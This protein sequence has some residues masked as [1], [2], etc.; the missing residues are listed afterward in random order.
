MK[1]RGFFFVLVSLML[2]A[3]STSWAQGR[4]GKD[5]ANC[6]NYLNFYRDYLKQANY[7]EASLQWS[8]AFRTCP[9]SASQLMLVDGQK[10]M[11]R[12]LQNFKGTE[13]QRQKILDTL[14]ML[15]DVRAANYPKSC[16][17][18][19]QSQIYDKIDF[20]RGQDSSIV[21]SIVDF[22]KTYGC[23]VDGQML[24]AAMKLTTKMYETKA[25]NDE[26]VLGIYSKLSDVFAEK[27]KIDTNAKKEMQVFDGMFA[28]S[29]VA[30]C[31]NLIQVFGPR[32]KAE[33][34]NKELIQLVAKLLADNDCVKTDLFLQSV[35][36]LH[37]LD[38]SYKSAQMLYKLYAS[39]DDNHNAVKYLEEAINSNEPSNEEKA[40]ML[41]ELATYYF[42]KMNNSP[43]AIHFAR[44][45]V[46][47]SSTMSGKANFLMG[48]IWLNTRCGGNEMQ[49]RAKY[50]V[51]TDYFIKA[52]SD[53]ELVNEADKYIA[54]ARVYY[55]KAEDAFM[56]DLTD[57]QSFSIYCGGMS[58]TTTVRTTK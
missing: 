7:K 10:L 38:P 54:K 27:A 4:F 15:A 24:I 34:D 20:L 17:N 18:A 51:A 55:P 6:V 31:D 57:G 8:G 3:G 25:V 32:F 9:P 28:M 42:Q 56:Y 36:A 30:S 35:T 44:Q 52:K 40:S 41:F 5:S 48:T 14:L 16:F 50:W 11:R 58:A 33:P 49:Q 39:K 23:D 53:P 45:A 29:G 19:K 46:E 47:K 37:K 22:A 12:K 21:S 2:L 26:Y 43:Q 13:E 1:R